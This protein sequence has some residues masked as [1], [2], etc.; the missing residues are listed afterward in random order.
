M[1]T[2]TGPNGI[3]YSVSIAVGRAECDKAWYIAQLAPAR[4]IRFWRDRYGW[5]ASDRSRRRVESAYGHEASIELIDRAI[6]KFQLTGRLAEKF[7]SW[8]HSG[9]MDELFITIEEV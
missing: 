3:I 1:E 4:T 8:R 7:A 2:A 5:H 9:A 6:A